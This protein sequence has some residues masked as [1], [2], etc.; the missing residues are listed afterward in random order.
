MIDELHIR[1]LGVIEE[2]TLRLAD[3]LTVVTG[4]TGAGK[5]MVV[6]A[7]Q[8]LLGARADTGLVRAGEEAA[9]AEARIRPA[10]ESAAEWL[11]G[12]DE[13]VVS[14]EIPADGRSRARINGRLAPVSAL[15]DALGPAVEVHAQ[16]EH[17]RLARPEVQRR[18][19]DRYA[20]EP[21]GRTLEEYRGT[22]RAWR[23]AVARVSSSPGRFL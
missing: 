7:L 14:R 20:G 10:P 12:D 3:G 13:L 22:Y 5:T 17:V 2:A 15:A 16:H 6:T 4:E 1:G 9:Y 11:D 23:T 19:V 8:L 21:H 18:L